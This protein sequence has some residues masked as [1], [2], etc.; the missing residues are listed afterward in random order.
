MSALFFH[1]G[2]RDLSVPTDHQD[3]KHGY[4]MTA[5]KAADLYNKL[6]HLLRKVAPWGY[7]LP[8]KHDKFKDEKD[9][10]LFSKPGCPIPPL[11]VTWNP[12]RKDS[13]KITFEEFLLVYKIKIVE[14]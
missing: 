7:Y 6:K 4:I 10:I 3:I 2:R 13:K 9:W 12:K 5:E 8:N 11:A 14:Y 1:I